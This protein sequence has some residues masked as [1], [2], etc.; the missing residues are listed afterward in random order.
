MRFSFLFFI[1]ADIDLSLQLTMRRIAA[2]L[3]VDGA[4]LFSVGSAWADYHQLCREKNY[5]E[6]D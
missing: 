1:A 5:G 3:A 6:Y 2:T 4:L